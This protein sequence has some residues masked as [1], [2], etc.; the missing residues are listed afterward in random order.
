MQQ[1]DKSEQ[2]KKAL[3]EVILEVINST[4][5]SISTFAREYDFDRGNLSK[6][7]RGKLGCR[8][9]TVW[10][11]AEAGNIDLI[12]FS[13]KLKRKLGNDFSLIDE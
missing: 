3:G 8:I 5:K 12:E 7:T 2:F 1:H 13:K 11:I 4:G 6:I 9:E 10:K